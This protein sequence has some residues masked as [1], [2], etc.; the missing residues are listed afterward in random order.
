M[1]APVPPANGMKPW[2]LLHAI[3]PF[4]LRPSIHTLSLYNALYPDMDNICS[5]ISSCSVAVGANL[6]QIGKK[7][8]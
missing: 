3:P 5:K 7:P 6:A 8:R 2:Q 1:M 4:V